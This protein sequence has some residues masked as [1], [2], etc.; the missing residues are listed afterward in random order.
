MGYSVDWT[1][2]HADAWTGLFR[3]LG[4]IGKP[5]LSF[6]EVGAFEGRSTVW[7][8]SHVLTD[9]S[10]RM[11]VIDTFA[12]SPEHATMTPDALAAGLF[13]TFYANTQPWRDRMVIH[14][15]QSRGV[16]A[17]YLPDGATERFD[18]AYLDGSHRAADVLTDAVLAW[19]LLRPGGV[20]LFDDYHWQYQ[21]PGTGEVIAPRL[22]I[23]AFL[24]AFSGQ[25]EVVLT[26]S[27]V[28]I[29]KWRTRHD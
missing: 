19:P 24:S 23:D 4:W 25:Y 6:L 27:Q 20:L 28:G 22:G 5:G 1:N 2:S 29:Q 16:L 13:E 8:L 9:P 11:T 21:V 12:G 18:L 17:T 10:S 7:F 26:N 14:C 15:G 3:R